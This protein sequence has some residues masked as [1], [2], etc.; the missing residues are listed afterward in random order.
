MNDRLVSIIVPVYNVEKYL[1]ECIESLEL[2]TYTNIEILLIDDESTD[3]SGIICDNAAIIDDRIKVIHKKNGGAASARNV[4]IDIAQGDYVCF[5]DSDDYVAVNYVERLISKLSEYSADVA[6]CSYYYL[7]PNKLEVVGYKGGDKLSTQVEY[8]A[9]FLND[10]TCGLAVNK[11][12]KRESLTDVRYEE[13]HRIDDEFFTYQLIMNAERVIE[14]QEPLYFYRMRKS[15]VMH[16]YHEKKELYIL[17]KIDYMKKR[18]ENISVRYPELKNSFLKNLV[19][20]YTRFWS[21]SPN[22]TTIRKVILQ[23]LR[24]H[25][26]DI[27]FSPIGIKL[28][29]Y[30]VKTLMMKTSVKLEPEEEQNVTVYFD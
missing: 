10:W 3:S 6:V 23:V 29:M 22:S 9:Q 1:S 17:D 12:F 8:L 19:E 18:L 20:N 14:F 16:G 11:V 28:K 5:V 15:S 24:I 13:G 25:F 30:L 26:F 2:Q 7:F 21:I 4:G 27:L